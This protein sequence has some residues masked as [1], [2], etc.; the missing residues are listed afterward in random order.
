MKDESTC[1]TPTHKG[2]IYATSSFHPSVEIL[3]LS[4]LKKNA[5]LPGRG[6]H[7]RA[8]I[9]SS[10]TSEKGHKCSSKALEVCVL[11]HDNLPISVTFNDVNAAVYLD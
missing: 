7:E 11:V 6:K 2:I 8:P 5:S 4:A 10:D 1:R 3:L 9:I